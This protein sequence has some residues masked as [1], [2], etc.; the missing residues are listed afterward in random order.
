MGVCMC[1]NL[2]SYVLLTM[3]SLLSINYASIKFLKNKTIDPVPVKK[4]FIFIAEDQEDPHF[5]AVKEH[6]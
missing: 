1:Q 4:P 2:P 3:C 5:L 6:L